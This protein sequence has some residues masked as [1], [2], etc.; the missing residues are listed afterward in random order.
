MTS[1]GVLMYTQIQKLYVKLLGAFAAKK[2]TTDK[3][4]L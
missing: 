3:I 4:P 2:L 1:K